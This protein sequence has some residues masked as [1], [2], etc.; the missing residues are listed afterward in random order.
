MKPEPKYHRLKLEGEVRL[1]GAYVVKANSVIYD[2]SGVTKVMATYDPLTKSGVVVDRKIKGTIHWVSCESAVNIEVNEYDRLFLDASPDGDDFIKSL[3]PNSL[4]VN[5]NAY[6]EP[7][8]LN[9]SSDTPVQ[10]M[11]KGYY[12][13]DS[14]GNCLNKTVSL[15][16][17]WKAPLKET[18]VLF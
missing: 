8:V 14:T 18:S 15:K 3:N 6:F 11:R 7:D 2:E 13:L 5:K 9:C 4:F 1:K 12:I 16:E 17:G 10:M